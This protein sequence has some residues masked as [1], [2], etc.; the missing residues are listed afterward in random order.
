MEEKRKHATAK[1][2]A[3]TERGRKD[4]MDITGSSTGIFAGSVF[5]GSQMAVSSGAYHRKGNYIFRKNPAEHIS[6]NKNRRADRRR[7]PGGGNRGGFVFCSVADL[8]SGVWIPYLAGCGTGKLYVLPA[9]CR[10]IP[11]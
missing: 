2:Q 9:A 4:E 10:K 1:K 11:S 3:V 5:W 8:A 7:I 6:E